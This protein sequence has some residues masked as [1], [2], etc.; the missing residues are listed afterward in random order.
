MRFRTFDHPDRPGADDPIEPPTS[1]QEQPYRVN[2]FGRLE[3]DTIQG[4]HIQGRYKREYYASRALDIPVSI[5]M[6]DGRHADIAAL[7]EDAHWNHFLFPSDCAP[8]IR[9]RR[10]FS[11]GPNIPL[12][13]IFG[14]AHPKF[15]RSVLQDRWIVADSAWNKD[16]LLQCFPE[17]DPQRIV[18]IPIYVGDHF[19]ETSMDSREQFTVGCVGYPDDQSNIKNLDAVLTL[20]RMRPDWRFEIICNRKVVPQAYRELANIKVF[21]LVENENSPEIMKKWSCYLGISKCERGPATIQEANTLG[22]PT[23]CA[24][25]TGYACF[26]PLVRLELPPF[27]PLNDEH[28]RYIEKSLS[29]VENNRARFLRLA[30]KTRTEYWSLRTP[31]LITRKWK[32]LFHE[33]AAAETN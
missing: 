16:A 3:E 24:N 19:R 7:F 6:H 23:V 26:N 8:A 21:L 29:E 5:K 18:I 14:P 10:N 1:K 11:I 25:H 2:L 22:C 33:L 12:A 4:P 27:V 32:G 17:L 31:E 20:A 28:L 13:P 9:G 30:D 15:E